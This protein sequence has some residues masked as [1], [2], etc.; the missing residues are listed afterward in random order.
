MAMIGYD[1]TRITDFSDTSPAKEAGIEVG[2]VITSYNGSKV[3][4]FREILVYTQFNQTGAPITITV[5][6]NGEEKEFTFK[7]EKTDNGSCENQ[8]SRCR[9]AVNRCF[10]RCNGEDRIKK[11][12][13]CF[14]IES[15]GR[16]DALALAWDFHTLK[17]EIV[18]CING[19]RELTAGI[20]TCLQT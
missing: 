8:F 20:R 11:H 14:K 13:A 9:T 7:P 2:D 5:D 3:Y 17:G 18:A 15:E 12:A 10:S 1:S 4:N 16:C 19:N 6:R